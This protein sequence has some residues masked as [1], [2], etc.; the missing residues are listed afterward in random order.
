[1]PEALEVLRPFQ[2]TAAPLVYVASAVAF[3]LGLGSVTKVRTSGRGVPL[4]GLGLALAVIGADLETG[5]RV[6]SPTGFVLCA[7]LGG[8]LGAVLA[9]RLPTSSPPVRVSWIGGSV[10]AAGAIVAVLALD[11][12]TYLSAAQST[13]LVFAGFS[14]A[15]SLAISLAVTF[16][17]K[18]KAGAIAGATLAAALA[19]FSTALLGFGLQNVVLLLA[20][21]IAGTAGIALGRV[22]AAASDRTLGGLL[23]GSLPPAG[24]VSSGYTDVRSSGTEEAAMV[25]ESASSVVVV[26]GYGMAV[27]QAQHAVKE[28]VEILDKRGAKV[29]YA[30]HPAAGCVPGHMNALF[31]EANI[32]H[33]RLVEVGQAASFIEEADAVVVVGANDVVNPAAVSDP[34]SPVFG[35]EVP[36]LTK[37]RSVFVIKRS[38]R[39]GAAG[40]KNTLF[41]QPNTTMIFGDAK[42]VVQA[43]IAELKAGA[44]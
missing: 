16:R 8:I 22:V 26:P 32:P 17:A 25:L 23:F 41:E 24:A 1:M 34:K 27:A 13:A 35:M 9:S 39:P 7:V 37:A 29:T 38:L 19:G 4:L 42:R 33:D 20:G 15:A 12:D 5:A 40:A 31:D 3:I 10:G 28:L 11:G 30:I 2:S 43:L 6:T 21:G 14:G 44:H 18:P 36:D